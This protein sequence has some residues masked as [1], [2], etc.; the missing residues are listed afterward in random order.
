M[1][2]VTVVH[3]SHTRLEGL[4][5]D[6]LEHLRGLGYRPG[7]L[8]NY[9]RTWRRF[10]H[11]ARADGPAEALSTDLVERFLKSCGIEPHQ[12]ASQLS[13]S[14]RHSRTFMRVLSEFALHGC[15]QC[16][17]KSTDRIELL[18]SFEAT[19]SGYEKFCREYL[20]HSRQSLR[21]RQRD[22]RRFLH[23]VASQ[24]LTSISQIRPSLFAD[25]LRSRAHLKTVSLARVASSLRSFLRYLSLQGRVDASLLAQ[26]PKVR[27]RNDQRIPSVW[28][29]EQVSA[30]LAAV[31][32]SSPC[33]KRD[34][35]ILLL[36]A[37]LG[38]RVGDI[39]ALCLDHLSWEQGRIEIPQSK[40]G[41]PLSLPLTEEIGH[42]L[43]D[44]LRHGRPV[45]PYREVFLRANAPFRPLGRDSNLY[46]VITIYR[47]RAGIALPAR[48]RASRLLEADI[49]LETISSVLGH[50]STESTRIY[51]K[52]DIEALRSAALDPEE[53][54]H[55]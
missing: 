51:T 27:V 43:I 46:H 14:Q 1:S 50:L 21:C 13:P 17:G 38:M 26:V 7:T 32:R 23:F 31:D 22:T 44:Y 9:Q 54:M 53:V 20:H 42:A 4:V 40:G 10:L 55:A 33:G 29:G 5:S 24:G 15:F 52:V 47:R 35:A 37:R 45:S 3:S 25:F 19:L 39:R 6:A 16:P 41:A 18:G 30:L 8:A 36:A 12:G 28:S 34:Y 11:F 49:P 48:S 2:T